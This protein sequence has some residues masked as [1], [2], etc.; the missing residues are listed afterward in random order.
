MQTVIAI[1]AVLLRIFLAK[2]VHQHLSATHAG[3]S[4]RCRLRQQLSTDVLFRHRFAFHKFIEFLQVLMGIECDTHTLA[5]V[6]TRTSRLL[7]V[8]FQRLGDIVMDDEAYIRFVDTHAKSDSCHDDI[9]TFHQEVVLRLRPESRLQSCMIGSS[10]NFVSPQ[11]L[12]QFLHLLSGEAVDDAALAWMLLNE[13]DDILIDIH[14]F[15]AYL[16]V[17]VRAVERA[18]KLLGIQN[19]QIL[20]D[21]GTHLVCCRCRQRNNRCHTNLVD[22]R[23]DATILRS[24]VMSPL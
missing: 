15:R 9:Y 21:I 5:A 6:T 4:I 11:Y 2:I 23:T 1:V 19:A 17:E 14:R 7:I 12:C 8:A 10:L 20:L 13:L 24:E 16:V 18:L 3:L 22:D